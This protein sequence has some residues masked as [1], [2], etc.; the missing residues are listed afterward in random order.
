V[1]NPTPFSP[2][3]FDIHGVLVSYLPY[4]QC[5]GLSQTFHVKYLP[6]TPVDKAVDLFRDSSAHL[7]FFTAI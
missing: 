5:L 7:P 1:T 3:D 2:L 4:G 6:E